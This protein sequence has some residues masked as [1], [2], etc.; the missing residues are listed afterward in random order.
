MLAARIEARCERNS[1]GLDPFSPFACGYRGRRRW[2]VS[3]ASSR[4]CMCL[5]SVFWV[6][7]HLMTGADSLSRDLDVS[8][9]NGQ[10]LPWPE[11]ARHHPQQLNVHAPVLLPQNSRIS[12]VHMHHTPGFLL[13]GWV[14]RFHSWRAR[15]LRGKK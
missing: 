13:L 10:W 2:K 14:R 7:K 1:I 12:T 9:L 8:S 6:K 3:R 11:V 5:P 15:W 4:P